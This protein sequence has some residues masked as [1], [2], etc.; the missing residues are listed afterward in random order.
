MHLFLNGQ[1]KVSLQHLSKNNVTLFFVSTCPLYNVC[2][3]FQLRNR[4]LI[5][6]YYESGQKFLTM[7][8]DGTGNVLYPFLNLRYSVLGFI[9]TERKNHLWL[10]YGKKTNNGYLLKVVILILGE[11]VHIL[12]V[13]KGNIYLAFNNMY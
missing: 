6:K 1:G 11:N 9:G 4:P 12:K 13:Y 10:C 8:P 2:D 7:F 3:I 5:E